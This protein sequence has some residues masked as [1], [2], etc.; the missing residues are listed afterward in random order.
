MPTVNFELRDVPFSA[1]SLSA[2]VDDLMALDAQG[3]TAALQRQFLYMC[4]ILRKSGIPT[5]NLIAAML[6]SSIQDYIENAML[7]LIEEERRRDPEFPATL[8]VLGEFMKAQGGMM[9]NQGIPAG[10]LGVAMLNAGIAVAQKELS[11]AKVVEAVEGSLEALTGKKTRSWL[12]R[13]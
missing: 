7:K 5:D 12:G 13:F 11:K 4:D 10:L 3:K 1:M 9:V 2:S 8:T 6:G